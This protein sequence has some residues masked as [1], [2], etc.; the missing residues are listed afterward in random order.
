MLLVYKI[1][2]YNTMHL[3]YQTFLDIQ[4]IQQVRF[5]RGTKRE[6]YLR[7]LDRCLQIDPVIRLQGVQVVALNAVWTFTLGEHVVN[8]IGR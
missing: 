1:Y 5:R 7:R 3:T 2:I 6:T 4:N 8:G